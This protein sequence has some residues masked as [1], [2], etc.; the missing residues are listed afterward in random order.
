MQRAV[1][2][3]DEKKKAKHKRI[4]EIGIKKKTSMRLNEISH[5]YKVNRYKKCIISLSHSFTLFVT[6]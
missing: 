4:K 3:A 6:F 2:M 5:Q 1:S